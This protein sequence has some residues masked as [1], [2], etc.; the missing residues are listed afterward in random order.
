METKNI[1]HQQLA[2]EMID[3]MDQKVA[4]EALEEYETSGKESRP[5]AE[6]FEELDL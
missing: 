6:L 1:N 2:E 5:I 3:Q 4:E